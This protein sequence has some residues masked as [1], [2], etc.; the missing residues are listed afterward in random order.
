MKGSGDR[1]DGGRI[2]LVSGRPALVAAVDLGASKI[3]CFIMKPDGLNRSE[4]TISVAGVAHVRSRGVRGGAVICVDEAAEAIAQAQAASSPVNPGFPT[5][6]PAT[7]CASPSV[8]DGSP[9]NAAGLCAQ[10]S[11]GC[12]DRWLDTGVTWKTVSSQA[13][14]SAA[15]AAYDTDAT[16]SAGLNQQ[17][18]IEYLGNNFACTATKSAAFNCKLYRITVRTLTPNTDR[19]LVMLQST[20]LTQ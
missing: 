3:G 20:F 15:S 6:V 16:L 18:L 13:P 1:R 2:G 14:A 9:C 4:R 10:P 8:S 17:Y 5:R 7:T 19:A 12:L 11:P